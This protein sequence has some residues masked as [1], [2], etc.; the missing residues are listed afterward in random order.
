MK[1]KQATDGNCRI[2]DETKEKQ[3]LTCLYFEMEEN[4][5]KEEARKSAPQNQAH[6]SLAQRNYCWVNKYIFFNMKG[7]LVK[8]NREDKN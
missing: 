2:K 3:R 7:L 8:Q 5:E 6:T 4:K 1:M